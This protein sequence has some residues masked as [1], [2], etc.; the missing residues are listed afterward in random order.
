M[1]RI[2]CTT[3]VLFENYLKLDCCRFTVKLF[4]LRAKCCVVGI[5]PDQHERDS[6][7]TLQHQTGNLVNSSHSQLSRTDIDREK[8][9]DVVLSITKEGRVNHEVKEK[10][11]TVQPKACYIY[12]RPVGPLKESYEALTGQNLLQIGHGIVEDSS[13]Y[14]KKRER[15]MMHINKGNETE[16]QHLHFT[17]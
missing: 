5:S 10:D 4:P 9:S 8:H 7:Y 11:D 14:M 13:V 2:G 15:D 6:T 1:F 3:V 12:K 17:L 16:R